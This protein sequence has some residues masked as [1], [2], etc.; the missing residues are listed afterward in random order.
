GGLD[1][2]YL[3]I[4]DVS[5]EDLPP[6]CSGTPD[7]VTITGIT[8]ACPGVDFTLNATG[9]SFGPGITWEWQVF[10]LLTSTCVPAP[11]TNNTPSYTAVGG[12]TVPT[13]YRFITTCANGGQTDISATQSVNINLPTQCYCTPTYSNGGTNDYV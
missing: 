8:D 1:G 12:I 4:D 3:Y 11:G 10:D 13:D 2:W 7:P 6:G 9:Y 5:I